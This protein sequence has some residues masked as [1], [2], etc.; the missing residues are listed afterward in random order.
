MNNYEAQTNEYDNESSAVTQSYNYVL[1]SMKVYATAGA[2]L[3]TVSTK[4]SGGLDLY[5]YDFT[6]QDNQITI[7][8]GIHME[9]PQGHVG[10]IMPRSST[11]MNGFSLKNTVGVID[12]DYR[13]EICLVCDRFD[14]EE[15]V[16][17]NGARIAQLIIVPVCPYPIE[18]VSSLED[19]SDTERGANGFGSTGV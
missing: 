4:G 19:L 14:N 9:I 1:P 3:P 6:V 8:T 13:G 17:Q 18:Q 7:F 11:G 10:L 2:K 12:A 15:V 16:I 5:I